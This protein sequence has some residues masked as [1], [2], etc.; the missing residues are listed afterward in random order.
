LREELASH[1]HNKKVLVVDDDRDIRDV[2]ADALEAEGYR[3]VTATDGRDAIHLL[4]GAGDMPSLILLDLMM[5]GMDGAQFRAEQQRDPVLEAIP[6]VVLS[7][8]AGLGAKAKSLGVAGH[9]KKPVTLEMLLETV[10]V[11]CR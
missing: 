6:V 8:D 3:V 7:A 11:C 9:L 1:A 10:R 5:P 4:R 2:V